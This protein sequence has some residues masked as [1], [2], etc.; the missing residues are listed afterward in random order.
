MAV[1]QW[2]LGTATKDAKGR[3]LLVTSE[4]KQFTEFKDAMNPRATRVLFG[5]L[6]PSKLRF[7]HRATRRIPAARPLLSEGDFRNWAAIDDWAESIALE[8]T[9]VF[10]STRG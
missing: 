10:A 6:N 7:S 3:E 8:L 1:Q 5:A 2:A 4:P 9:R